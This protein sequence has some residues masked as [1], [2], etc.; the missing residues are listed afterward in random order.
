ML[1]SLAIDSIR[2]RFKNGIKSS[3]MT[4]LTCHVGA[5]QPMKSTN[6]GSL[7]NQDTVKLGYNEQLGTNHFCWL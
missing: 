4:N 2:I 1:D 7:L 3:I 6:R 5:A